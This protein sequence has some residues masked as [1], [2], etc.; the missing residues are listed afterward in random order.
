[1]V[2]AVAVKNSSDVAGQVAYAPQLESPAGRQSFCSSGIG[3][4]VDNDG[5]SRNYC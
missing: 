5:E 1:M 4:R 3:H 2:M